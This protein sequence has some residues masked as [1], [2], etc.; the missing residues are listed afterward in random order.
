MTQLR[1]SVTLPLINN[2]ASLST[3]VHL[4]NKLCGSVLHSVFFFSF[5]SK[6][7]YSKES[8]TAREEYRINI[9]SQVLNLFMS[10]KT[11]GKPRLYLMLV[12]QSIIKGW[13]FWAI[14]EQENQL[15]LVCS[16]H[17]LLRIVEI[18]TFRKNIIGPIKLF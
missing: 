14:M 8:K 15:L 9:L 4:N 6:L 17:S 18:Y 16:V 5:V 1:L 10:V 2:L 12:I 13:H 11:M 3:L 7:D